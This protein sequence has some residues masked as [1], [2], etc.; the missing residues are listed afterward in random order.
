MARLVSSNT[1]TSKEVVVVPCR[2]VLFNFHLYAFN[3][4]YDTAALWKSQTNFI[5][6]HQPWQYFGDF[7]RHCINLKKLTQP[8]QVS[9]YLY[10]YLRCNM[11]Q[12]IVSMPWEQN[13]TNSFR[14]LFMQKIAGVRLCPA[15]QLMHRQTFHTSAARRN[16]SSVTCWA[17]QDITPSATPGKM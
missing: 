10:P 14:I 4:R 5:T 12:E 7:S 15:L 17:L 13:W 16:I 8:F 1:R 6:E 9:I 11:W 3:M 2:W